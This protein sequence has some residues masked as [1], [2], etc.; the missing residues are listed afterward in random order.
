MRKITPMILVTLML[1]SALSSFDFAELEENEVIEDVGARAGADAEVIAITNPKETICPFEATCRNVMKVGDVTE[2]TSYIKNSGDTDITNMAYTVEVWISN[3]NGDPSQ[4]AKDISGNDLAWTNN[5]VI[6]AIGGGCPYQSLA[7]GDV[8]GGGKHTMSNFGTPIQWTPTEGFYVIKIMVDADLD[9]TPGNDGEQIFVAVEDWY[10][11]EVDLAWDSGNEIESGTGSKAWTLT[12]TANASDTFDPREVNVRI[13]TVGDA[14]A[15]DSAGNNITGS[16]TNIY[17]AGTSTTVDVY[18]DVSVEPPVVT[19]GLRNVL[20]TWTLTGVLNVDAGNADSASYGMKASMVNYTQYGKWT[21]CAVASGGPNNTS[22]SENYCEESFTSDAY[23]STD[24]ASI[25]GF[26]TI[27]NDIRISDM[28]IFQGY[29]ADGTG[30]ATTMANDALGGDINVGTSYL[31]VEVEHRG[32]SSESTYEWNV[33]FSITDPM[34]QVAPMENITTCM[35]VE[36][37][38]DVYSPLGYQAGQ[39]TLARACVMVD[40]SMDGEYIFSATLVN[41]DKMT[42]AKPSNN[43]RT[44]TLNVRNN[45][46]LITS[47]E[48]IVDGILTVERQ[49]PVVMMVTVFDVDDPSASNLEIEWTHD[50]VALPGCER[51]NMQ[52]TITCSLLMSP[53]ELLNY[54]V[55]VTVYDAHGG[56]TS[57]E[58]MLEIW[59]AG[60]FSN[61]TASGLELSYSLTFWDTSEFNFS[62]TDGVAIT[63]QKLPA[64]TGLYNSVGVIDYVPVTSYDF[65]SV[66]SQSMSVKLDKSIG[67]TSLWFVTDGGTWQSLAGASTDVDAT[68]EEFSYTF[69]SDIGSFRQGTFVLMGGVLAQAEVPSASITGFNA[70]AAKAGAIQLNW[71]VEGTMLIGDTLDVTICETVVGEDCTSAFEVSLGAGNISYT[72]AGQNTVHGV[73]YT[74]SVAVCNE[75]GCSTPVGAGYVVSDKKVDGGA[76]ATNL[77]ITN[78]TIWTVSWT[79]SGDQSD[80]ASW[81]VCHK[82]G[83]FTAAEIDETTCVNVVGTTVELDTAN[84]KA[85]TYTAYVSAMPVDALG[86]SESAGAMNNADFQRDAETTNVDDGTVVVGEEVKS[87]VPTWTWGVIGGVVVVAFIAGAFILSRGG[88]GDEGKDWDY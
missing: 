78:G 34:G 12:V 58:L 50:G 13:Q 10:D 56:Q 24:A 60:T 64:Y 1:V 47:L 86:N 15:V 14:L 68:T 73:N 66:R 40:L 55:S 6:C 76:M 57:K 22:T 67:A 41:G 48:A 8:L 85:G 63:D 30:E 77:S 32:S 49:D 18:E 54:P 46:P 53:E 43:L 7:A 42:D 9:S 35:A 72:Y 31:W 19:T 79:A 69:P 74:V 45:A 3:A 39:E 38:Y 75:V 71:G 29:N 21:S 17:T 23:P 87:G 20:S 51:A 65:E 5:N 80:V 25:D 2:F 16:S 44:L 4:L 88:A 61:M 59:N 52:M 11:I 28:A 26:A 82:R 84:W 62:A 36:P 81:N 33:S 70:A 83:T 37:V 27:F